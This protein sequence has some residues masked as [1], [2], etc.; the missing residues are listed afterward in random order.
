MSAESDDR[1]PP[2][3]ILTVASNKLINTGGVVCSDKLGGLESTK[4]SLLMMLRFRKNLKA[5]RLSRGIRFATL[6]ASRIHP[7]STQRPAH[8][9][10]GGRPV[11]K[12]LPWDV[13]ALIG[14]TYS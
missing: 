2:A 14:W 3:N 12:T 13:F 9:T 7:R 6:S 11:C 4:S 10:K 5:F 1:S 8:P